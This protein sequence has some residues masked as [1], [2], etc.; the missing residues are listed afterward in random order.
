MGSSSLA[1]EAPLRQRSIGQSS[2]FCAACRD[3]LGS[4]HSSMECQTFRESI[5]A[6]EAEETVVMKMMAWM[7]RSSTSRVLLETS[8][9]TICCAVFLV[10]HLARVGRA[11]RR[12]VSLQMTT[13]CQ[14]DG[15]DWCV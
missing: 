7:D 1:A 9:W 5:L 15:V 11:V 14:A 13:M 4:D 2:L 6:R 12:V 3:S 10:L 8:A